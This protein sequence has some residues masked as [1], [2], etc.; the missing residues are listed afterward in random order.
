MGWGVKPGHT[1]RETYMTDIAPT[2][3]ALL[4]VQM[5]SGA[6]GKVIEEVMAR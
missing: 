3:A 2:L 1:H 6:I 5:P 4:K